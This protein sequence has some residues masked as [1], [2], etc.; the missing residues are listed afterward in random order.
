MR[1]ASERKL[2]PGEFFVLRY[3]SAFLRGDRAG[4]DPQVA[5]A[6]GQPGAEDW[7]THAQA[8][9]SAYAGH[10]HQAPELSRRAGDVARRT[11]D[12][13]RA[14]TYESAAA[15]YEAFFGNAAE[16][17][18]RAASALALSKGRDVEYA[19]AFALA[20][21]GDLSRSEMLAND[22]DRRFPEDTSVQ[23]HYLP[24]LRAFAALNGGTPAKAREEL[25]MARRYELAMNGLSSI[26]FCGAMYPAYVRG[27]A[28]LA[29]HKGVEAAVEFKKLIDHR[30]IVLADPA[31]AL[32]RLEIARAWALSGDNDKAKNAYQD[33]LALWKDADPDIP[34]LRQAKVEYA[35]LH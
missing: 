1:V 13:E 26:A 17:K 22:L 35:R 9:V 7:V 21:V 14:A 18:Q 30:G 5:L 11:S 32:A 15:A 25:E 4:M 19:A 31:A 10:L 6:K 23:H 28:F 27:E 16:A 3:Y 12:Q 24:T 29:E 20:R 8:L 33:F 2:K 34:I